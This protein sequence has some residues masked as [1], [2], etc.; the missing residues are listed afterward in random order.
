MA[1]AADISR[2]STSPAQPPADTRPT[3]T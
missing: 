2:R 1:Y 3:Q